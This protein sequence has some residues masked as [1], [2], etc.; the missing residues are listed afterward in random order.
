LQHYALCIAV[1]LYIAQSSKKYRYSFIE[2]LRL[3][4]Q[5]AHSTIIQLHLQSDEQKRNTYNNT[6]IQSCKTET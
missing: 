3:R 6:V 1:G 2:S 5:Q 4:E